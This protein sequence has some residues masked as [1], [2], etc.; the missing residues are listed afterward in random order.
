MEITDYLQ[1]I[2]IMNNASI[3]GKFSQNKER[4]LYF[5]GAAFCLFAFSLT[6]IR[7][8]TT[9]ITYDEATTYL[10]FCRENLLDKETLQQFYAGGRAIANNHW[11]NTFLIWITEKI[12]NIHYSEF[13][14]RLPIL[15][16]YAVYL[17]TALRC[18][19]PAR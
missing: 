1:G 7:A 6:L 17:I 14:I 9:A 11:L 8:A 13:M 18:R 19:E 5:I 4:I 10:I 16:L 3:T 12:T 15:S 2:S